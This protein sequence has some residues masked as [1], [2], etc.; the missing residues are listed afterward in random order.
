MEKAQAIWNAQQKH[1]AHIESVINTIGYS[2]ATGPS[3]RAIAALAQYGLTKESG[4]GDSRTIALS[5]LAINY[6]LSHE[7]SERADLLRQAALKPTVFQHLWEHYGPILPN[8]DEAIKSHLIRE[9]NYN[10]AAVGELVA[11]Y[12]D[13]FD[14]ANLRGN[15]VN[16]AG[17]GDKTAE[18]EARP[19]PNLP[20]PPQPPVPQYQ[21]KGL[22]PMTANVRYLPIPLDIGDAHIPRGM[23]DADFNLLLETLRLWKNK[24][25]R[26][27]NAP[28]IEEVPPT[29]EVAG[30]FQTYTGKPYKPDKKKET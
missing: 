11:S 1:A 18:N 6:L 26:P 22:P 24:I 12:R 28:L 20:T 15:A 2:K 4:T 13:T 10:A 19:S 9:K 16:D 14:F 17:A 29:P 3:L 7:D 30:D 21:Q 5:D 8:N 27:E 23:N 25:V